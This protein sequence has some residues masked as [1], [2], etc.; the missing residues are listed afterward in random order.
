M[1][2]K[3]TAGVNVPVN[4]LPILRVALTKNKLYS[5][6]STY[7]EKILKNKTKKKKE[8]TLVEYIWYINFEP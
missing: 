3:K 2:E 6:I 1:P 7:I 4:S 8:K 5:S